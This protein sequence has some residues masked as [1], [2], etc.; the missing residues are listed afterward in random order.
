M[1]SVREALGDDEISF[2]GYGYS[3][4]L[5]QVYAAEFPDRVRAM[6]LDGVLDVG[7]PGIEVAVEQAQ[8]F[9][10]ALGAFAA[11]CDAEPTCEIRPDAMAAIDAVQA[12]VASKPLAVGERTLGP[13]E[14]DVALRVVLTA[15]F[16]RP[17]LARA[18]DAGRKGDG[19]KLLTLA[20]EQLNLVNMDAFYA[21]SCLDSEWPADPAAVLAATDAAVAKAP[22]FA[23]AVVNNFVRCALWPT[24]PDVLRE[25]DV[26]D[27]APLLLVSTTND[28]VVSPEAGARAAA[29][30][31]SSVLVT[32]EGDGH[33]SVAADAACVDEVVVRYLTDLEL[34]PGDVSC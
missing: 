13:G 7:R 20:D 14:L 22:H 16:L 32:R 19:S 3:T 31:G 17:D 28:P 11:G 26:S 10:Q 23:H 34:P 4:L 27:V 29:R 24:E 30:L 15:G 2:V 1:D 33:R 18:I 9:E 6:V 8:R 21:V 25:I 5:G 12:Q